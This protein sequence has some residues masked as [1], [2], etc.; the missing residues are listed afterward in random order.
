MTELV[1]GPVDAPDPAAR[2][3]L[4]VAGGLRWAG[5]I[6]AILGV[7]GIAAAT[8]VPDL[9]RDGTGLLVA[10]MALFAVST[11]V[12]AVGVVRAERLRPAQDTTA[13]PSDDT[14]QGST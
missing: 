4:R 3:A 1:G 14:R 13:G 2:R 6:G 8:A 9:P 10:A 12:G 5:Q 7:L 11:V